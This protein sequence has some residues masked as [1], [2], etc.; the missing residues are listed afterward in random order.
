[1]MKDIRVLF[2]CLMLS[3][4]FVGVLS[5]TSL[6]Y[7]QWYPIDSTIYQII[8]KGWLVGKIPYVDLWDQKGPLLYFI[9]A[10]G[11][12]FTGDKLGLFFVE[13]CV[14]ACFFFLLYLFFRKNCSRNLTLLLFCLTVFHLSQLVAGGNT[15]EQYILPLLMLAY[16]Y[17]WDWS[18][19]ANSRDKVAH[20]PTFAFLYGV[21]FSVSMLTRLTNAIGV[22]VAFGLILCYLIKM[23][24]WKN[25]GCNIIAFFLSF[26]IVTTP[27]LAYFYIHEGLYEWFYAT[28]LFNIDYFGQ[29]TIREMSVYE[30]GSKLLAYIGTYGL[31]VISAL[32]CFIDRK[33]VLFHGLWLIVSG[34]T[35]L[36]F[37]RTVMFEHYAIIAVPYFAIMLLEFKKLYE[38]YRQILFIN[39]SMQCMASLFVLF[40]VV[41]FSFQLYQSYMRGKVTNIQLAVYQKEIVQNSDIDISNLIG[42]G[43]HP[44]IYLHYGVTPICRFFALQESYSKAASSLKPKIVDSFGNTKPTYVLLSASDC[45]NNVLIKQILTDKYTEVDSITSGTLFFF[46]S[47]K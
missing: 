4:L 29:S 17:I 36:Y 27:F 19:R 18:V 8:G 14:F 21:I 15:I 26:I 33:K 1:M 5:S 40:M 43:V 22:C 10:I 45:Q 30:L 13:V 24:E 37:L 16:M 44:S 39:K 38:L 9:N 32:L 23:K 28:I 46:N 25:V 11:Y 47:R 34:I 20:S 7:D 12:W 6:I 2:G 3:I 42:Y 41:N 31:V 35:L